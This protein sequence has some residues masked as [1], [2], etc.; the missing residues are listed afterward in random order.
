MEIFCKIGDIIGYISEPHEHEYKLHESKVNRVAV[1]KDGVHVYAKGFR[2]LDDDDIRIN[3]NFM[4]E[5]EMILTREPFLM[6]EKLRNKAERWCKMAN[7]HPRD[8]KR[9]SFFGPEETECDD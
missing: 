7:E 2:P 5:P 6:D 8:V 3:T 4:S 1:C 9:Y